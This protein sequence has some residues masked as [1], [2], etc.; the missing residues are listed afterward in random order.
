[1]D[2]KDFSKYVINNI[3][4]ATIGNSMNVA[5]KLDCPNYYNFLDFTKYTYE[6]VVELL[7]EEKAN[8]DKCYALLT[9][10]KTAED[11]YNN[12]TFKYNKRFIIDDLILTIWRIINGH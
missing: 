11:K 5:D 2:I 12:G 9:A 1:M 3:S 8:K 10:I 6:Y 4:R 7:K